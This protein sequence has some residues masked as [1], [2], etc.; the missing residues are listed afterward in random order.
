LVPICLSF[1]CFVLSTPFLLF[2][3]H[4]SSSL[5]LPFICFFV[6]SFF[7][8]IIYHLFTYLHSLFK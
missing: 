2:F 7:L 6:I 4:H 5:I 3:S 1:F 8:H